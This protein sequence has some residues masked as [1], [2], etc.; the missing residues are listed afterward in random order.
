MADEDQPKPLSEP[1]TRAQAEELVERLS[2]LLAR[3]A[4][5]SGAASSPARGFATW[6][7]PEAMT[8]DR[9]RDIIREEVEDVFHA[10]GFDHSEDD[11]PPIH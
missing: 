9:L 2:E 10:H 5:A 8:E 3:L 11:L 1:L 6:D 4:P 7:Q